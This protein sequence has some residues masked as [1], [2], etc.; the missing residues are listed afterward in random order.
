MEQMKWEESLRD[1][2]IYSIYV[3]IIHENI[4]DELD[5]IVMQ[6]THITTKA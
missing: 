6:Y 2:L 5:A 3:E 1:M 4:D